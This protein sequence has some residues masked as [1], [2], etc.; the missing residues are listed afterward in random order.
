MKKR[1]ICTIFCMNINI[2]HMLQTN[3]RDHS[4]SIFVS[5]RNLVCTYL[6]SN[7]PCL[8][9]YQ[10]AQLVEQYLWNKN[11]VVSYTLI[12]VSCYCIHQVHLINIVFNLKQTKSKKYINTNIKY[13]F[14]YFM[15]VFIY[16]FDFVPVPI[17]AIFD[18]VPVPIHAIVSFNLT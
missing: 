3:S 13:I 12:R 8:P 10:S 1:N 18:F 5:I 16:F 17:H 15:F 4:S 9:L 2:F 6:L 11:K 14:L 7:F